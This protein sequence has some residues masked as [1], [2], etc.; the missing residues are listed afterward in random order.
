MMEKIALFEIVSGN[1]NSCGLPFTDKI[2]EGSLLVD[3]NG[4]MRN[5][6][7]FEVLDAIPPMH[8]NGIWYESGG[9]TVEDY[10]D[11]TTY[12]YEKLVVNLNVVTKTNIIKEIISIFEDIMLAFDIN[13]PYHVISDIMEKDEI[14]NEI[15][16]IIDHRESIVNSGMRTK[17]NRNEKIPDT[18]KRRLREITNLFVI[19]EE[20]H[21]GLKYARRV[22]NDG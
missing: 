16:G 10:M 21:D 3:I 15:T 6:P 1:I 17:I 20:C 14:T 11:A 12:G 13:T 5:R 9:R 7:A 2:P 8:K 4:L 18:F 19:D 22:K